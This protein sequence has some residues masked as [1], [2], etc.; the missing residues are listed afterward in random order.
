MS[1]E[2]PVSP[3]SL[4]RL[5]TRPGRI[6]VGGKEI[7]TGNVKRQLIPSDHSHPLCTYHQAD[8]AT[9]DAAIAAA[10]A[11]RPRWEAM[12]FEHRAAV[13][14]KAADLISTKYRY[15]LLA[16]TMLGQGKTVWQ[17]EIDAAAEV[18]DFFRFVRSPL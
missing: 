18:V 8:A 9:V 11:A 15:E 17:A 7:R 6:V 12:P 10:L 14:L 16:A 3:R 13:L 5:L 1:R 2:P 4:G